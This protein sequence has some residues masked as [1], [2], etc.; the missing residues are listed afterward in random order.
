[1][2]TVVDASSADVGL[3]TSLELKDGRPIVA[4]RDLANGD[5]KL[6]TCTAGCKTASPSWVVTI[7]DSDGDTGRYAQL[8]LRDGNPVIS[9][10]DVTRGVLKLATCTAGCET[11]APSWIRTTIDTDPGGDDDRFSMRLN[12]GNPVVSYNDFLGGGVKL[13]TCTAGCATASPTWVIA[14]VSASGSW[15]SLALDAGKPVVSYYSGGTLMLAVCTDAC[16]TATPAWAVSTLDAQ[17]D[18][19]WYPSLQLAGGRAYVSYYSFDPGDLKLV[20]SDP[21]GG[22]PMPSY[23]G[24]W[25]GGAAESGWGVNVA[26][27][28]DILFV[29]WFTYD[30]DGTQMWLLGPDV[31][32][33]GAAT[34]TGALYRTTGPAFSSQPFD[35]ARVAAT[36]VGSVSLSFADSGHGTFS[37]VVNGSSRS[38]PVVRQAFASPMPVCALGGVP[39]S[40]LFVQGLWYASQGSEAGWGLNV[41]HQ[42]DVLFLTWFT[43]DTNGRGMWVVGP[44]FRRTSDGAFTGAFY[45]TSGPAFNAATW[46]PDLVLATPV[47]DGS[48][49]FTGATQGVFQYTVNGVAQSKTIVPQRFASTPTV[50]R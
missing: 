11:G 4:Y 29:T 38:K 25:W 14:R 22:G 17:G 15:S 41:A 16:A 20:V 42:G 8:R 49:R 28:S 21:L 24:L 30:T 34:Y 35:P 23:A 18:V 13:A 19:G 1:V 43:Y 6:A 39:G 9:Y 12:A 37:Y 10:Y 5:L 45:R 27:E 46:N 31:R 2:V 33:S 7:V 50:C 48:L 36:E 47:G 32:R 26:H 3:F 40:Q 44:D